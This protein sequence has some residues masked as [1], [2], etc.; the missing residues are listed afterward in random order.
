MKK[1][2]KSYLLAIILA[3]AVGGWILSGQLFG[4]GG[5]ERVETANTTSGTAS[6]PQ[7]GGQSEAAPPVQMRV[8]SLVAEARAEGMAARGAAATTHR[9]RDATRQG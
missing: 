3:V 4:G 6:G 9:A 2:K 1:M 7:S 8:K 5:A